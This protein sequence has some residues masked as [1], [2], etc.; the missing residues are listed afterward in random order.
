MLDDECSMT[1]RRWIFAVAAGFI[2]AVFA[3]YPQINLRG[4]R[5]G[6]FQGAF[7]TCDLDEMAYA[8]YLQALIDGRP[9]RSDPYTGRDDAANTPQPESLFSIQFFPPYLAAVPA[10]FFGL[11]AAQTMPLISVF[12]AFFTAVALFWLIVSVTGDDYF[13]LVGTLVV[14]VGS[15]ALVGLG[16]ING[17]SENGVAYPFFP[18]LRRYIPSVA[19][20]FLFAFLA[21]LWNGLSAPNDRRR[22]VFSAAASLC[23]AA[24]VYSYFYVWT[25]AAAVLF[26]WTLFVLIFKT[27]NRRRDTCFLAITGA[28]CLLAL[29]P[30]A[31]LLSNRDET[32]DKAQLLVFTRQPDL[33]RGIAVIGYLILTATAFALWRKYV[34]LGDRKAFLIAALALSPL[35]VF[36]QQILTARSLQPF[37]YE[38]YVIN[39]VVLLAIVLTCAVFWQSL[40]D[41]KNVFARV[42]LAVT[43]VAAVVWGGVEARETTVFWDSM[44][45]QRDEAMPVNRRLRELANGDI[46][47]ARHETTLNLEPLQADSQPTVAPQATLWARHQHVFAGLHSWEENKRRYYQM[48]YYSDLDERWLRASL[49]GCRN[50]EAC[51]ALF[52]W[53]RFNARLS[54][55]SRPLTAPEIAAEVE[56]FARYV[57]EFGETE[58][59]DPLISY[60]V[61]D[62]EAG[63]GLENLDRWYQRDEGE[64]LGRYTLYRV[65]LK[66]N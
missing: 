61:I 18:F 27:V 24:L 59:R 21:C 12:S 26:G 64:N 1:K 55:N 50:I 45:V 60:V 62:A 46:E 19:F 20:P 8:S 54:A 40:L 63:D 65:R 29:A 53:D 52:G 15:A 58:A 34:A 4:L 49:S 10:R 38:F 36:N 16:A 35:L 5:G 41:R 56:N 13:A 2:L 39:Y 17:F 3:V 9:R 51:M 6:D 23:F 11:S 31:L 43:G 30:Y 22:A 48:L 37:H 47:A 25:A 28:F 66:E 14:A 57:R 7:A 44:N 33:L 42:L 32:M